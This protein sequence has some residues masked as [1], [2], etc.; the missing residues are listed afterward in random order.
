MHIHIHTP[1]GA[2]CTATDETHKEVGGV[3]VGGQMDLA[4]LLLKS[5]VL[6]DHTKVVN[7]VLLII[8]P[9]PTR[10]AQLQC[11]LT[12][13]TRRCLARPPTPQQL[14]HLPPPSARAPTTSQ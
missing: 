5:R 8:L 11:T 2:Y 6:K 10:R 12:H 7:P 4:E 13:G 1:R 9:L 14:P 3:G